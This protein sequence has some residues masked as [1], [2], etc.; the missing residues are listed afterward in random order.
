[1][2][3]AK[4]EICKELHTTT[5][6]RWWPLGCGSHRTAAVH[7]TGPA[8]ALAAPGALKSKQA[9]QLLA[10]NAAH[11]LAGFGADAAVAA[12]A[13][14]LGTT[15]LLAKAALRAG[16]RVAEGQSID[17][18]KLRDEL[19]GRDEHG[20]FTA[21]YNACWREGLEPGSADDRWSSDARKAARRDL[22]TL[23]VMGNKTTVLAAKMLAMGL[24]PLVTER[25]GFDGLA[26]PA[27][28]WLGVLGITPYAPA[29]LDKALAELGL[30]AVDGRSH[31]RTWYDLSARWKDDD[32]TW[33]R[34]VAYVD[35][36]A[37]PYLQGKHAPAEGIRLRGVQ[38]RLRVPA[39][40]RFLP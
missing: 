7:D 3:P 26:G 32:T 22:S 29:T 20:H 30:L 12:A 5:P 25:R 28:A 10:L 31:S 8:G 36:T 21:D 17:M 34:S 18:K 38:M 37:D 23:Q 35:G 27:G 1:L 15:E 19:S 24:A 16:K 9:G 14:E 13:A 11:D 39:P 2:A 6:W 4:I 40:D 33:P